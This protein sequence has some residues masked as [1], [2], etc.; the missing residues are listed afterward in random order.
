MAED[1]RAAELES[2]Q[3][4][5]GSDISVSTGRDSRVVYSISV[6]AA[7]ST[8]NFSLPSNYPTKPPMISV[9]SNL[10]GNTRKIEEAVQSHANEMTGEQN[11]FTLYEEARELLTAMKLE[12]AE[13]QPEEAIA[14]PTKPEA[15]QSSAKQQKKGSSKPTEDVDVAKK[16]PMRTAD[17]VIDRLRY[18]MQCLAVCAIAAGNLTVF[19]Q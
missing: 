9:T 18:G 2:L 12:Q 1:E 15:K 4:V 10:A 3:A 7:D 16:R 5:F 13:K 8:V 19:H 6:A 14:H 11:I 17:D